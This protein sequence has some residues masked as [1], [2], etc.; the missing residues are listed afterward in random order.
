M[1]IVVLCGGLSGERDVSITSGTGVARALRE[2]GHQVVLVDLFLGIEGD[3]D[4][5]F[6]DNNTI[7]DYS[8]S[9]SA[10]DLDAVRAM[11][12]DSDIHIGPNVIELCRRADIAFLALHGE[13]GE[14]GKLQATLDM[15]GVK[16]TG[17][18]Y[19]GSAL[20]MNKSL[21]KTLFEANGIKTAPGITVHKDDETYANVG[22]P[23]VV[24]P[25]DCG[26]SVGVSFAESRRELEEA[27]A[28]AAKWCSHVLIEQKITGRELTVGILD[29]ETLPPVE[30]IPKEGFYDYKN[31]YQ[32]TTDEICPAQIPTEVAEKAA[33]FLLGQKGVLI[34]RFLYIL[35]IFTGSVMSLDLVWE[36]ADFANALL[37]I[38][39]VLALFFLRKYIRPY[40]ANL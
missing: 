33:D 6:D 27:L 31:K 11:R 32:G 13:E 12:P 29:G 36:L 17:S 14:N 8:V 38:P 40:S 4:N 22:F 19:L 3:I 1:K 9:E 2:R 16:Y 26:S 20:A 5:I 15:Y 37:A 10:P 24:K 30:I 39:N 7:S 21:S 35:T 28:E 23:C 18:G 25:C 34:C